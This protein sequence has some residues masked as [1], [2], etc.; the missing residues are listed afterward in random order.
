[1]ALRIFCAIRSSSSLRLMR[2]LSEGSDFDQRLGER[3]EGVAVAVRVDRGAEIVVEFL[4]DVARELEVLLLVL[5]H[6][7]VGRPV[8]EDVGCHQ[9]RIGVQPN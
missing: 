3:E 2:E 8:G 5:A 9:A 1:M 4:R 7:H 6:R